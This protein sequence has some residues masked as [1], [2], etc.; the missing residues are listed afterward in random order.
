MAMRSLRLAHYLP[1]CRLRAKSKGYPLKT[2][3]GVLA[4][5][6]A[7]CLTTTTH[8]SPQF[9]RQTGLDCN[10]CHASSG[11]FPALNSFGQAFKAGGYTQDR[12]SPESACAPCVSLQNQLADKQTELKKL[13][14]EREGL[15]KAVGPLQDAIFNNQ[16]TNA[17]RDK[18][19]EV[20]D[21]ADKLTQDI[22][23]KQQEIST[24]QNKLAECN[25]KCAAPQD[26][27]F[28]IGKW[29]NLGGNNPFDPTDPL[30]GSIPVS[31]LPPPIGG[32]KAPKPQDAVRTRDC[33]AGQTG[34]I[35]EAA[36]YICT[37]P[38][39]TVGSFWYLVK[40]TCTTPTPKTGCSTIFPHIGHFA[41]GGGCGISGFDASFTPGSTTVQVSGFGQNPTATFSCNGTTATST[42]TFALFGAG[43]H[44]CQFNAAG[45]GVALSCS[46]PGASCSDSCQ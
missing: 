37:P 28:V 2:I 27:G 24:V 15:A 20:Q 36:P 19:K 11:K 9:A 34:S 18:F 12:E 45:G 23:S 17:Q 33:P 42:S 6:V 31:P 44:S 25:K 16:A 1:S 21:K 8:G 26:G 46:R 10:S 13:E 4:V 5:V 41:C 22:E 39:W 30:G 29:I 3:Y 38:N 35:L 7:L 32:C 14:A 40:N 43:G